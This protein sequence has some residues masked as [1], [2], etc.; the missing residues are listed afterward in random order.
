VEL[1]RE[2]HDARDCTVAQVAS[3]FGVTRSTIYRALAQTEPAAR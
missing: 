3:D 2:A 1:V